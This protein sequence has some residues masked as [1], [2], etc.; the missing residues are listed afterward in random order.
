MKVSHT[1]P[2]SIRS[3]LSKLGE[4]IAIARRKRKMTLEEVSAASRVAVPTIRRLEAGHPGVALGNL[5]MVL[6]AL[7]EHRRLSTLLD[8]ATDT[9][10]LTL[11]AA[12][13]TKRVRKTKGADKEVAL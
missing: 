1:Y 7:G 4:D 2:P 11:D 13:L 5:A 8:M 12:R 3:A 6:L 9:A 10:G